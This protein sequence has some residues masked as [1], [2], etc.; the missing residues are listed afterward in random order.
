LKNLFQFKIIYLYIYILL[1]LG[2][3]N[4]NNARKYFYA[5]KTFVLIIGP[6]SN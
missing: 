6:E 1:F 3:E 5:E 4:L 2:L